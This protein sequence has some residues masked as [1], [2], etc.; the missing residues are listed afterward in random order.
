MYTE[1]TKCVYYLL[2]NATSQSSIDFS[3]YIIVT[4][5]PLIWLLM[6]LLIYIR[7]ASRLRTAVFKPDTV[8]AMIPFLCPTVVLIIMLHPQIF[9]R[10]RQ[11]DICW[12][13][14]TH[15][16][17]LHAVCLFSLS[18]F[19]LQRGIFGMFF[20]FC[21]FVGAERRTKLNLIIAF[22]W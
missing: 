20:S 7:V 13:T 17:T 16:R 6:W 11:V 5:G 8:K 15:T 22:W 2:I 9:N 14:H 3:S 19:N 4:K 21:F 10:S 1:I 18:F 12:H